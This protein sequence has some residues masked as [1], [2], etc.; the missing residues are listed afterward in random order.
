[1]SPPL[2]DNQFLFAY[3]LMQRDVRVAVLHGV[4]TVTDDSEPIIVLYEA[5]EERTVLPEPIMFVQIHNWLRREMD[6]ELDVAH[7][8]SR[9]NRVAYNGAIA[10]GGE[11][12]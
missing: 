5:G 4:C 11:S 8:I 1:M 2:H 12:R 10:R 6:H 7:Q 9:S 3:P